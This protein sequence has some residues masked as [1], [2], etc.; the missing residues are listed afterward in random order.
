VPRYTSYPTAPIFGRDVGAEVQEACLRDLDPDEPVSVYLH[1]PFCERLC[2]FCACQTQGTRTLSPVESYVETL[3][4]ELAL[5]A[6]L[7]PEGVRMGQLHWGGGTPTIL[8][9]HLIARVAEA[10]R[11]VFPAAEAFEFSVETDPTM[12]DAPKVAALQAAGMTRASIGIQDFAPEV[13]E[14][15][16]RTQSFETTRDC[17]AE[18]RE[19]GVTSLNTDLVY[20]LPHQTADRL[21]RT[22]EQVLSLAPD[23]VAL[24]GYAHVPHMSKRQRLID[25]AALPGD[26][27]RFRLAAMAHE[28]FMGAGYMPIGI[29]HYA[30]P[31]DSMAEAAAAGRLRR[32]FQGYTADACQTLIGLGASS[33]SRFPQGYVQNA[34][35]TAAYAQK[36]GSGAL[37]GARGHV[38]SH[39]DRLRSRAIEQIMCDFRLDQNALEAEFGEDAACLRSVH[40]EVKAA[41]GDLVELSADGLSVRPEGR[42]V[43]RMIASRYDAYGVGENRY[44]KAS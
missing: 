12:I 26:E 19:A 11:G 20:G 6:R 37:A 1:I 22:I 5:I 29:D 2:W 17:I 24:F 36:I 10:I 14:A 9:P 40:A 8:P 34:T 13:Q 4:A 42:P 30:R 33:I 35:A 18:L 27:E 32:N 25:E 41:F 31:G 28:M 16:G 43:V 39:D 3:E 21:S 23:R 44:S 7:L 15:I 38:F